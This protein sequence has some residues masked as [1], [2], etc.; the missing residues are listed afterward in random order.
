MFAGFITM[1]LWDEPFWN[2]Q[3]YKTYQEAITNDYS[4]NGWIREFVPTDAYEIAEWH[5]LSP[6][7][8]TLSFKFMDSDNFKRKIQDYI[9]DASK[10][11]KISKAQMRWLPSNIS[12]T[13][14]IDFYHMPDDY[15]DACLIVLWSSKKAYFR[16]RYCIVDRGWEIK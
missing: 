3:Y 15:G 14:Q 13:E 5:I 4:K 2:T 8:Q 12:P 1:V 9:C 16:S 6:Q 11:K 7:E 10:P